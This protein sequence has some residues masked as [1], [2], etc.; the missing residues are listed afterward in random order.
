ME[1]V[2]YIFLCVQIGILSEC[3]YLICVEL[4]EC[5]EKPWHT[6]DGDGECKHAVQGR[7]E[8]E[9]GIA[10]WTEAWLYQST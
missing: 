10:E 5:E 2:T 7:T 3:K 6:V 8:Q 9:S 4:A 1:H